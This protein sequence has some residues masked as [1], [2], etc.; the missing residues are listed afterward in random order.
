MAGDFVAGNIGAEKLPCHIAPRTGGTG[1][2]DD[3][4]AF[5]FLPHFVEPLLHRLDGLAG[6]HQIA[7]G[8]D[9]IVLIDDDDVGADGADIHADIGLD[10]LPRAEFYRL[11]IYFVAI[12]NQRRQ[13]GE[14]VF[15]AGDIVAYSPDG[16]P[17]EGFSLAQ[18]GGADGAE[19]GEVLG[20]NQ[21]RFVK[22]QH[23][24]HGAD[25]ALVC[26][27]PALEGNR[28]GQFAS[29]DD[30]PLEVMHHGKAEAGDDIIN[31]RAHLLQVYHVALG[32]NTA[33]PGNAGRALR[34]QGDIAQLFDG[35]AHARSLLVQ[36]RA[37]TGGTDAVEGEVSHFRGGPV[38]FLFQHD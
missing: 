9:I 5:K 36:E 32:E 23:F 8:Q 19:D 13:G 37:G 3:D 31:G 4:L 2:P 10:L 25:N 11:G 22:F 20:D 29:A 14:T 7:P 6:G 30:L 21:F 38:R 15:P 24:L 35:Y 1:T 18:Q 17:G 26:G 12:V 34:L 33:A 27:N 28:L 16:I